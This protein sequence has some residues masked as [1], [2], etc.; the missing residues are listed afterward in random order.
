[1]GYLNKGDG[2]RPLPRWKGNAVVS[3]T[4]GPHSLTVSGHYIT[5]YKDERYTPGTTVPGFLGAQPALARIKSFTTF[6]M[7]Y[8][9]QL[10]WDVRASITIQNLLDREPPV[11]YTEIF[12]DAYTASGFGRV[13]K[14]GA[15]K[16]F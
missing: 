10:P 15:T 16:R 7:T 9:V 12:Y 2:Q 1:M 13:I 5:S 11:A 6:D 8:G 4:N 14:V 3:Y